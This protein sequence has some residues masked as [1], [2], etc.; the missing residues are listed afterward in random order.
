MGD[1]VSW[2]GIT[3]PPSSPDR[4]L[5][6]A[7]K[8]EL[9]SVVVVGFNADGSEFFASSEADGAQALWHL[10]RAR[11]RLMSIVDQIADGD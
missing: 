6:D 1:V 10:E 9:T 7:A 3:T 2:G 5:A 4:V 8:A 11:H